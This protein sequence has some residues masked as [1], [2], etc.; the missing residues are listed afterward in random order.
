MTAAGGHVYYVRG[1]SLYAMDFA[2]G[3][4][5]A[6]TETAVSG[7]AAGDGQVWTGRGLFIGA[8]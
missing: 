8:S 4:P 1:G 5:V 2:A 3:A 7:T 6:G